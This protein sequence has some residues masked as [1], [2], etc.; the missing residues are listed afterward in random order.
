MATEGHSWE[1]RLC[2]EA[3]AEV[4]WVPLAPAFPLSLPFCPALTVINL[5]MYSFT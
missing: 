2:R 3:V 1:G 5:F 4:Y